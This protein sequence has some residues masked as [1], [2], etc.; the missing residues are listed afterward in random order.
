MIRGAMACLF[1]LLAV[2]AAAQDICMSHEHREQPFT[3]CEISMDRYR[4]DL[5]LMDATSEILGS[6]AAMER[7]FGPAHVAM[8]GGMY[9]EDRSPVG[10]Y[11]SEGQEQ[12]RIVTRE[13]PGNFGMLPNGVF[14]AGERARVIESRR[15]AENPPPCRIATQ[16]GPML[17]IDGALHPRF[18]PDSA[19][20]N[21]RNAVGVSPD[22]RTAYFVISD[23]PVTFHE[24]AT[25]FRDALGVRDALYMDGRVSK[26]HAG[27]R[28]DVGR[29]MGPILAVRPR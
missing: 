8:N 27:D 13:G 22:G 25:L 18:L 5:H 29:R 10:L 12:A 20:R 1:A 4:I 16:S 24:L 17:V 11:L 28:S 23:A 7:A 15:Y 6:F 3:V 26:L 21:I 2:P 14:C 9:H 19:S